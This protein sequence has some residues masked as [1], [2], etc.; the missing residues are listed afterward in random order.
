M[1]PLHTNDGSFPA[2]PAGSY[3]NVSGVSL[4]ADEPIRIVAPVYTD[5]STS[6]AWLDS[7]QSGSG[8]TL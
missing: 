3:L 8:V 2:L 1:W 4:I 7:M 5:H 6:D